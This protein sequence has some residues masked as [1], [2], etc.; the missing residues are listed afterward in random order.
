MV[1]TPFG[2]SGCIQESRAVGPP[3]ILT[4]TFLGGP[5]SVHTKYYYYGLFEYRRQA[6][7]SDL[8]SS[9]VQNTTGLD[10]GPLPYSLSAAILTKYL[11]YL[12]RPVDG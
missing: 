5:G 4:V 2:S 7:N 10:S 1:I 6:F 9:K 3:L 8:Q 12:C 11:V